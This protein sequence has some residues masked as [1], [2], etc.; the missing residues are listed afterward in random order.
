MGIFTINIFSQPINDSPQLS[1]WN[2]VWQDEFEA[3]TVNY[4]EW[5]HDIGTGAS[6][7]KSYGISSTEFVPHRLN[8]DKFSVQWNGFILPEFTTEY[9]FYIVADDGVRIWVDEKLIIDKW[10]SQAPTEWSGK[11]KLIANKKYTL[12]IDYFENTGGETLIFGWECDHFQKCLV[13]N[14]RLFTPELRQGLSG[15]Y[16]NEISLDDDKMNQMVTR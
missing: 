5:E 8:S 6:T 9:T 13:P 11:I 2:L 12:K 14:D 4:K 10:I 16:Y 15:Q 1:G 7:Y 3:D